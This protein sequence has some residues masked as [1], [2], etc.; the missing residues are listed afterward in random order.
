MDTLGK[1]HMYNEIKFGNQINDKNTVKQNIIF[2]MI[3]Q[4]NT[5]RGHPRQ[6]NFP[7]STGLI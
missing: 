6:H 2:D 3:I 7:N 4:A 1:F 5:G